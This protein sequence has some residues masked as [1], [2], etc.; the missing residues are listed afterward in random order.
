MTLQDVELAGAGMFKGFL[1]LGKAVNVDLEMGTE[2]GSACDPPGKKSRWEE[3]VSRMQ[4]C[5]SA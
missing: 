5:G 2:G 1:F 4:V 3:V